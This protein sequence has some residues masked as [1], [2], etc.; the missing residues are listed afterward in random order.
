M[1]D[2]QDN[3]AVHDD[4]REYV[5]PRHQAVAKRQY[6][7]ALRRTDFDGREAVIDTLINDDLFWAA[8]FSIGAADSNGQMD[9]NALQAGAAA[10]NAAVETA[11]KEE[12]EH[13]AA[14]I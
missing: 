11:A 13:L 9:H 8:V 10:I 12:I 3:D 7:E 6:L 2:R 5:E 4:G 14:V 1:A